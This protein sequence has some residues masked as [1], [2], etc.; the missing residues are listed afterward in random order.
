[1]PAEELVN[2]Y[3]FGNTTANGWATTTTNE[4]MAT[5]TNVWKPAVTGT[6]KW[7]AIFKD[8][9]ERVYDW[10]FL[11]YVKDH[12]EAEEFVDRMGRTGVRIWE[13]KLW[14]SKPEESQLT[15]F[16]EDYDEMVLKL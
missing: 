16:G 11:D 2:R 5:V 1:M 12:T 9:L 14:E 15:D 10:R 6:K 3:I 7:N 4:W 8:E 13:R